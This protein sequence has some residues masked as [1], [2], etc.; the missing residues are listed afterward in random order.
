VVV[1]H[2]NVSGSGILYGKKQPPLPGLSG[3]KHNRIPLTRQARR[4]GGEFYKKCAFPKSEYRVKLPVRIRKSAFIRV[5]IVSMQIHINGQITTIAS[6]ISIA[7]L[8]YEKGLSSA[9]V[10]VEQNRTI[11][12]PEE[13]ERVLLADNDQVEIIRFVGGG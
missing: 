9:P 11:L 12:Q 13:Y 6:G 7:T 5:I 4:G 2:F 8:L 3:G 1:A 10:V